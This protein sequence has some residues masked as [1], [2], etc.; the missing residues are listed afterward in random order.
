M[1]E[2]YT[3]LLSIYDKSF[4]KLVQIMDERIKDPSCRK[5]LDDM[6]NINNA[7]ESKLTSIMSYIIFYTNVFFF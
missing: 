1:Y 6:K 5:M 7:S 2:K 3:D 4:V